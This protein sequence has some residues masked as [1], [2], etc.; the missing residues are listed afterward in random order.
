MLYIIT[1][2]GK[3]TKGNAIG[4]IDKALIIKIN[5]TKNI[6]I[7]YMIV[8]CFNKPI[9]PRSEICVTRNTVDLI[10]GEPFLVA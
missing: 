10:V 3:L 9:L 5:L 2:V 7:A 6:Y 4:D 1:I 8:T